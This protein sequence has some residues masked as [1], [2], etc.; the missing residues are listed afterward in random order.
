M[1]CDR[2]DNIMLDPNKPM[3]KLII[4]LGMTVLMLLSAF[5]VEILL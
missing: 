2:K 1:S 5:V 4:G 3:F